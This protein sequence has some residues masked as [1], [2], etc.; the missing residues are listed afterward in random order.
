VAVSARA[1]AVDADHLTKGYGDSDPALTYTVSSGSL[2]GTDSF[3][4]DLVRAAGENVGSYPITQGT[5]AVSDGNGGANYVLTF[6]PH[7][8]A[9]TPAPLSVTA[10]AN[11]T[12]PAVDGF[13]KTYD[14]AV[15]SA[16]T[17]RYSGFVNGETPTVLG[18]TLA[19]T[20]AGTTATAAGGPYVVTPAGLTSTN[21]AIVFVPG[22]LTITPATL[23]IT[24]ANKAK[25]FGATVVF[26]DTTPSD[27]FSVVGL[28]GPDSVASITLTSAGAPASATAAGSPYPIVPSAAVGSGLNNYSIGYV[29][30]TLTISY[31][32]TG[33]LAPVDNAVMNV[34]KAGSAI[35]LKWQLKNF[36]GNFVLDLTIVQSISY[37]QIACLSE[38]ITNPITGLADDAGASDL[39]I[40][41]T[42]YHF[43]W[44]TEK[45]WSNKCM[46]I[47]V[48][49]DDASVHTARFNFKK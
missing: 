40:S 38:T 8:L 25:I 22:S 39:R 49:L 43:N 29:N 34:V 33:F 36:S 44:K 9:I 27:D 48:T 46:V 3:T 35:P 11:V 26:D 5:L 28:V 31:A 13:T 30:G 24:A 16:F 12:T 4:G 41:G 7:D 19:F 47:H 20:G 32:F 15:F 21:Y 42:D 17:V 37:G 1:I 18:G 45:N 10:D 23:T 6:T 2:A 14:N